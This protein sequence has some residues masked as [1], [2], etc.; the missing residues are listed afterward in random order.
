MYSIY[1]LLCMYQPALK[2]SSGL[3]LKQIVIFVPYIAQKF[4][5][6]NCDELGVRKILTGKILM[7]CITLTCKQV[8]EGNF[9]W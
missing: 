3:G 9:E 4:D 2:A 8:L 6:G 5:G 1:H 7:N